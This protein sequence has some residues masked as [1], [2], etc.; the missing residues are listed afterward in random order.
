[1]KCHVPALGCHVSS[2]GGGL[3]PIP[4]RGASQTRI[5]ERAGLSRAVLRYASLRSATQDQGRGGGGTAGSVTE[6]HVLSWSSCAGCIFGCPFRH[7]AVLSG[8]VSGYSSLFRCLFVSGIG[9]SSRPGFAPAGRS[10]AGPF[11][12]AYPACAPLRGRARLAPARFAHLIA[13]ARRWTHFSRRLPPGLF[14]GPQPLL[15]SA[16]KPKGGP[17]SRLLF[18]RILLHFS[19]VSS[20]YGDKFHDFRT[21]SL[22]LV[23]QSPPTGILAVMPG[24][25]PGIHAAARYTR[26]RDAWNKS[27]HDDLEAVRAERSRGRTFVVAPADCKAGGAER[28][29]ADSHG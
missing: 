19:L 24:L 20:I 16:E 27:G 21:K 8:G 25:I 17:G 2:C 4:G 13:R 12:R 15:P 28:R 18:T 14:F 26:R 9:P 23:R 29:A 6:C 7:D 22:L 11:L 1:M 10:A 3:P 5:E